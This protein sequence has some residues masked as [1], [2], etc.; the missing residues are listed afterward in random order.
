MKLKD[1]TVEKI[2]YEDTK[3]FIKDK[4][5]AGRMP[6]ISYRYGLFNGED[7]IGVLTIGKPASNSLCEGIC[8]KEHKE[9]VFELNRLITI[10]DLPP[11]TLSWFVSEV[12]RDLKPDDLIIVSYADEGM[13]HHGYVYQATNFIYTGKTPSR[14]D[15]YTPKGKHSR[16]YDSKDNHL[17]K[18]RTSKHR[19]VYFTGKSRKRY[20]KLLN[21]GVEEYPKG[22]NKNYILG[23][24]MK[25]KI[26]NRDTDEVFYE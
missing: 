15:K 18:V 26:I 23:T 9:K 22:E 10:D 11:N 24:K 19:Y 7:L 5:Y 20:K 13:N 6:S 14:T 3:P 1:F 8:G 17:R 21:Y 4:H 16:H 12:L 25:A 2:P